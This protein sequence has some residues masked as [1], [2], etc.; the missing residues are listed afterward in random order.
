[1]RDVDLVIRTSGEQR[2]SDF[3]PWESAYA[4]LHFTN[5]MWP[6]FS[7]EDLAEALTAFHGRE[8]RFGGLQPERVE[9]VKLSA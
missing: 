2:L 5:R 9:E 3:M 8:R 7:A 6:D 4:E 1:L